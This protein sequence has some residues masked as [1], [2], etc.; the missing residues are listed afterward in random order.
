M[1]NSEI[2]S[3]LEAETITLR[4]DP[5]GILHATILNEH[6]KEVQLLRAFPH[7]YPHQYI[8]VRKKDKEEIGLIFDLQELDD[9]SRKAALI[10][11]RTYYMIPKVTKVLSIKSEPGLWIFNFETDRGSIELLLR[12]VHDHIQVTNEGYIMIKDDEHLEVR[13]EDFSALDKT[14][15]RLLQKVL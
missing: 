14:S 1:K 6:Y 15:K 12:N 9:E 11:L 7:K 10:Q 3:Y 13:I 8:S 4:R 5:S 2:F